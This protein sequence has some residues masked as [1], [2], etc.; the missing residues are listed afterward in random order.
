MSSGRSGDLAM[1][2]FFVS[3][4][5]ASTAETLARECNNAV[6]AGRSEECDLHLAHPL[7]SRKHA[8]IERQPDGSFVI[9]DL[10]SRN[11]TVVDRVEVTDASAPARSGSLVQ[12][13]PFTLKL[14]DSGPNLDETVLAPRQNAGHKVTLERDLRRVLIDGK[15]AVER[16]SKQEFQFVETLVDASPAVVQTSR[17][18]DLIWG[19]GQWDVYM[20]HNLV[21]RIR[22]KFEENG[23]EGEILENI[24]GSGYRVV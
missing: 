11:G 15:V 24:P 12:I 19:D 9:T 6:V 5:L 17:V 14:A 23:F 22:R 21:R 20:L 1:G 18:G 4:T 16:L 8:S 3:I 10:G 7:V 2:S 13:G